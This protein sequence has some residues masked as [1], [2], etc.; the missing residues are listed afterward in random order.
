MYYDNMVR[1]HTDIV[2]D[3]ARRATNPCIGF[4]VNSVLAHTRVC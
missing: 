3:T 4:Y 1:G 2:S